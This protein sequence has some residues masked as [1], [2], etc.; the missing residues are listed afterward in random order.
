MHPN[1]HIL[2]I[3]A[4]PYSH[5]HFLVAPLLF[6]NLSTHPLLL[7][8]ILFNHSLRLDNHP[9]GNLVL[10]AGGIKNPAPY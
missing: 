3:M 7:I 9:L 6:L 2:G 4:H 8:V 1:R 5:I 10:H